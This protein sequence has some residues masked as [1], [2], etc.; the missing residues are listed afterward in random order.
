MTAPAVGLMV[1]AMLKFL[2]VF[3]FFALLAGGSGWLN[4]LLGPM[5]AFGGWWWWGSATMVTMV[6]FKL[7]PAG[8]ILYGGYQMLH[9]RS[10]AWAMAAAIISIVSCGFISLPL[11]IWALIVLCGEDARAEFGFAPTA[12]TSPTKPDRFWRRFAVALVLIILVPVLVAILA[13]LI[14][15]AL[16]ATSHASQLTPEQLKAAG[17]RQENGEYKKDFTQTLPLNADG[18]FSLD[19][20]NGRVE[21]H[22]W[23]SNAAL[24]SAVIHGKNSEVV[25]AVNVKVDSTAS[26]VKVHTDDPSRNGAVSFWQALKQKDRNVSVDYIVQVPEAASLREISSVNGKLNIDGVLGD[27]TVST[28]NGE[29]VV[30]NANRNLKLSTVNGRISAQMDSLD[31]AQS[32]SLDSVNGKLELS[33]PANAS[34]HVSVDTLNGHI[35][36]EFSSLV[37]KR[38]GPIGNKLDGN[39]GAGSATVKASTVNGAVKFTKSPT[40]APR[41]NAARSSEQDRK[42]LEEPIP[43]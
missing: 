31:N 28:V 14:A 33:L 8:L 25:N 17:I 9:R 10:Y 4:R 40:A 1:G 16:P 37:S 41:K 43:K 35:T 6:L 13:I 11:G 30:S 22:G 15:I 32:V 27:I 23:S 3:S 24:V 42:I 20:I 5:N 39:V 36:S 19:E 2:T 21:I 18:R 7:I 34:A 29:T 38:Q 26:E 12:P